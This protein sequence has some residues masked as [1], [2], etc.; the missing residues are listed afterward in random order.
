M[1]SFK[2]AVRLPSA[3]FPTIG[4][5]VSGVVLSIED[6]DVPHFNK[7]GRIEGVETNEDGTT[8]Q[9][10]DVLLETP[11]GKVTLHTGGGI[12]FAI[13]RALGEIGAEDLDAGDTLSVSY[14]ADG[15]KKAGRNPAKQY[16]AVVTKA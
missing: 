1:A 14:D 15:P 2:D 12:M 7:D 5:T 6:A 10:I 9:Q 4:D 8:K 16:S 3:K 11:A 13:G